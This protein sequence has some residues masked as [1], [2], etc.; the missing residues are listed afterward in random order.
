VNSLRYDELNDAFVSTR[1]RINAPAALPALV[2]QSVTIGEGSSHSQ[3][4]QTHRQ[5]RGATRGG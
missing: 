1:L 2:I 5:G 4:D 3:I